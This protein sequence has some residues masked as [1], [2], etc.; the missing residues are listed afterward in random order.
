MPA[1]QNDNNNRISQ[2]QKSNNQGSSLLE[3]VSSYPLE[4][5]NGSK[6]DSSY[7]SFTY[8]SHAGASLI[9][10]MIVSQSLL[11]IISDFKVLCRVESDHF[12]LQLTIN[13]SNS[14][15][16]TLSTQSNPGQLKR[17][18]WSDHL[19]E[20]LAIQLENSSYQSI[21]QKILEGTLDP[22]LAFHNILSMLSPIMSK[23]I[24]NPNRLRY[25]STWFDSECRAA[26]RKL[27]SR[28][29][30]SN[31]YPNVQS[32]AS[33]FK[34]SKIVY[35]HLLR[36]K[37]L[38]FA[39]SQWQKLANAISLKQDRTF[40]NLVNK[41]MGSIK[42]MKSQ[43]IPYFVW[44]AHFCSLYSSA[45]FS[46]PVCLDL[47]IKNLPQ[48]PP[49]SSDEIR[50]L[51][52]SL[53]NGKSPGEDRLPPEIFKNFSDWWAPILA[54]LF[55]RIN[56]SGI[57][58]DGWRRNIIVPIYKR[59]DPFNPSNYRPISLLNVALKLYSKFLLLKLEQ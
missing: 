48:W 2:D 36:Q 56:E 39:I 21:H 34:S 7:G 43:Q 54:H 1:H 58:P 51:I 57:I 19:R 50:S 11:P 47:D 22:I 27:R 8:R 46:H 44:H 3:L 31:K 45:P 33:A 12:P 17:V 20:N 18:H 37:K 30:L 29:R 59:S 55:S 35:R 6:I 49:V 24:S 40:W 4:I 16:N 13:F 15:I 52:D 26:K 9:D 10:Y 14:S 32:F 41:G 38:D 5:L 23:K 28:L 25:P 42:H 53:K